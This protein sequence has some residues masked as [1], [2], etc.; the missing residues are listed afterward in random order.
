MNNEIQHK[1]SSLVEQIKQLILS[2]QIGVVRSVNS[3]MVHT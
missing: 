2:A 1:T 3:I